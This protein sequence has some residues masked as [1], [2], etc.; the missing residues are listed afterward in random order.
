MDDIH[1]CSY[2]CQNPVCIKAQRDELRDS[3]FKQLGLV[4]MH[5]LNGWNNA[6]DESAARISEMKG[7]GQATHDSFAVFIQGLKR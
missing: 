5:Y 1:S 2:H 6:L 7:F 4:N 3:Y